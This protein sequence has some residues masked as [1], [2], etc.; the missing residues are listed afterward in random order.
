[1]CSSV[2]ASQ[3]RPCDTAYITNI[4]AYITNITAYI[5]SLHHQHHQPTSPTS[6]ASIA[7]EYA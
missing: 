3:E 6:P 5:T 1:M 2:S 7:E 4:T